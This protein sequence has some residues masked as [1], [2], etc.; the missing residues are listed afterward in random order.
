MTL[1]SFSRCRAHHRRRALGQQREACT[2]TQYAGGLWNL[3]LE[4]KCALTHEGCFYALSECPD[5]AQQKLWVLHTTTSVALCLDCGLLLFHRQ[6]L[7]ARVILSVSSP[8]SGGVVGV[9]VAECVNALFREVASY[10]LSFFLLTISPT[11]SAC[12][13]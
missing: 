1:P 12:C 3:L 8:S 11:L 13:S 6:P 4:G 5:L 2:E 9:S 7:Q 10:L